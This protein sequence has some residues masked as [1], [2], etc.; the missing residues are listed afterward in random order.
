ML[1]MQTGKFTSFSVVFVSCGLAVTA[2]ISVT[3]FLVLLARATFRFLWMTSV[4]GVPTF[5]PGLAF[6]PG[7]SN[8]PSASLTKGTA[9]VFTG[10]SVKYQLITKA[11][12]ILQL[13]GSQPWHWRRAWTADPCWGNEKACPAAVRIPSEGGSSCCPLGFVLG[14]W[15]HLWAS[16][17]QTQSGTLYYGSD[18]NPRA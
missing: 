3:L 11:P 2:C 15:H 1:S 18:L 14:W 17:H 5:S 4:S 7:V 6:P 8:T 10:L 9:H 13:N 12:D 16:S